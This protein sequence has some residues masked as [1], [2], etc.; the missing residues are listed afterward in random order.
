[1]FSFPK[2]ESWVHW[3]PKASS[4]TLVLCFLMSCSFPGSPLLLES[5]S[6]WQWLLWYSFQ[7]NFPFSIAGPEQ[8]LRTR[9][10]VSLQELRCKIP[11]RVCSKVVSVDEVSDLPF[12][13]IKSS[14]WSKH[15]YQSIAIIQKST[16]IIDIQLNEFLQ[17]WTPPPQ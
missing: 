10:L 1:M 16:Q 9:F 14:Y 11:L 5:N 8:A 15:F 7:V 6:Y 17:K 13:F 3:P 4:R 2:A 12:C